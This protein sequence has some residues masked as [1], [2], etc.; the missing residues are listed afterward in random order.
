MRSLRGGRVAILKYGLSP[1]TAV[2]TGERW[3]GWGPDGEKKRCEGFEIGVA[4][5][6]IR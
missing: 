3:V 1:W 5:M 2:R 6:E 4:V